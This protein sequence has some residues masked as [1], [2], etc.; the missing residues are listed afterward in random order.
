MASLK[1]WTR[2]FARW[3]RTLFATSEH[4]PAIVDDKYNA[5][6]ALYRITDDGIPGCVELWKVVHRSGNGDLAVILLNIAL[7]RQELGLR[8]GG[9]RSHTEPWQNQLSRRLAI[10]LK[11]Q[12]GVE[13]SHFVVALW[14]RDR[15]LRDPKGRRYRVP[16]ADLVGA[17]ACDFQGLAGTLTGDRYAKQI[18]K[19]VAYKIFRTAD[20]TT[21]SWA[22][23]IGIFPWLEWLDFYGKHY[24]SS[25]HILQPKASSS[26]KERV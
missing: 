1:T 22:E 8:G 11:T 18:V 24:I 25:D 5:N 15:T 2:G 9:D 14:L 3:I 6:A 10:E 17:W 7:L 4:R 19:V 12:S 13:G 20:V 16:A 23:F 21:V 26:R